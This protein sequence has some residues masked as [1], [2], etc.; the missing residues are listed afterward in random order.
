MISE[1]GAALS[2]GRLP[3]W[4]KIT[5]NEISIRISIFLN[6]LVIKDPL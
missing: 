4:L 2:S 3:P 5:S 6:L 1:T